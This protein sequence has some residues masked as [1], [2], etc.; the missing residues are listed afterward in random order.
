MHIL[1]VSQY[2]WPEN[3]RVNDIARELA[4]RGH[5]VAV[6][7]GL[8]NYPE[9]QVFP[10]FKED[11]ARFSRLGDIEII[12]VP[13]L[14]RG[15]GSARLMLNYLSFIISG[16]FVGTWKLRGRKFDSIFMFETSPITSAIPALLY[17]RWKKAPLL[18][19]VL[20]L[21]PETLSAV[22]V[23]KSPRVLRLVG[24]L[25]SFIYNRC[26][27]I[28]IQSQ[29]FKSNVLT[30]S[31]YPERLRYFP[32]WAEVDSGAASGQC[33]VAP[34]LEPYRDT[35]NILF[36][37]NIGEAQDFPAI[38]DAVESLQDRPEVRWLIV[39]S[40]RAQAD[41]EEAAK[42]R[43]L[44]DRIKF[45]GRFPVERMPSFFR[46]AHA[47]LVSLRDDPIFAMTIPGK[48]QTYLAS[49]VP[50]LAMLNGE[51][52]RIIEEAGAGL[53]CPAGSGALLAER[54]REL[55]ALSA[56]QRAAMGEKGQEYCSREFDRDKLMSSLETWMSELATA[57]Q[58]AAGKQ[59]KG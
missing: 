5:K 26:D 41:I 27:R 19:W 39:G 12:R 52:A 49:G 1:I 58:G 24:S 15:S 2:F 50:L 47:L 10:A 32:A 43:G 44:S 56:E 29:A 18:M 17:R 21:W 25:V 55:M 9:G 51:G 16:L 31:R 7:T 54:V 35:F 33:A 30:Y 38:L 48:V 45:L 28:L 40:G 59:Q 8:P 11:P 22:G 46:G 37:G 36:A 34:E 23:V 42:A 57:R 3:F 13:L 53:T 6:L 20:D 14:P 4:A